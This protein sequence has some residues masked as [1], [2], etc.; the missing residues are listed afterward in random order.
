MCLSVGLSLWVC[1][2]VTREKEDEGEEKIR[3][4]VSKGEER[5]KKKEAKLGNE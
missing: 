3:K 1:R 4:F 5:E 2:Y